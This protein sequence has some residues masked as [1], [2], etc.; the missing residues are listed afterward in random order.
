[1]LRALVN[2]SPRLLGTGDSLPP[3]YSADR[4]QSGTFDVIVRVA[5]DCHNRVLE[6]S[7]ALLL[8][9]P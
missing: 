8:Y 6:E 3:P 7:L 2:V 5:L 1:M 4:L 9:P